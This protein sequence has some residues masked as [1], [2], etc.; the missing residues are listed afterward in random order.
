MKEMFAAVNAQTSRAVK[1]WLNW[2][3]FIF[4]SSVFFIW[5]HVPARWVLFCMIAPLLVAAIVFR[6]TKNVWLI[7]IGHFFFWIPLAIYLSRSVLSF[8][9]RGRGSLA[10]HLSDPFFTWVALIV[11]TIGISIIFDF[12]D[13]LLVIM[14]K[15]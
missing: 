2:M 9:A 14:G 1:L 11:L 5:T 10:L 12:R 13:L 8:D 3:T 15:K 7:G 6:V 4:G